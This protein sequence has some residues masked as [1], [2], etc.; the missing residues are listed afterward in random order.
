MEDNV[1]AARRRDKGAVPFFASDGDGY[2]N[3]CPGLT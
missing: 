3:L 1:I 2:T